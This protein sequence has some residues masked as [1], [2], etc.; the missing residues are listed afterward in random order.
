MREAPCVGLPRASKSLNPLCFVLQ[1]GLN[2]VRR[3]LK[4]LLSFCLRP[5]TTKTMWAQRRLGPLNICL[6][7]FRHLQLKPP[8]PVWLGW[9]LHLETLSETLSRLRAPVATPNGAPLLDATLLSRMTATH[10][11]H[12]RTYPALASMRRT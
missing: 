1:W 5:F 11:T 8:V 4:V 12:W 7:P 2:M 9:W 3:P 6:A 10:W